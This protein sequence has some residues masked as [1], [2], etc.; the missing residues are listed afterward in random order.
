MS[1]GL[2]IQLAQNQGYFLTGSDFWWLVFP[3]G[4]A[5]TLMAA[6]FFLVGRAMDEVINPR[7]RKR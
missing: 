7:L 5:V 3:S 4:L 6:A 2:M 1:W